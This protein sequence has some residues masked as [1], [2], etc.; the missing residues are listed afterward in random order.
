MNNIGDWGLTAADEH[1]ATDHRVRLLHELRKEPGISQTALTRRL[2]VGSGTVSVMIAELT[3]AGLVVSRGQAKSTGGRPAERLGLNP[4]RPLVLGVDLG[5]TDARFGVLNLHGQFVRLDRAPLPRRRG[6]VELE[7]LLARIDELARDADVTGI[8]VAVPGRIDSGTGRVI[9]A[10]NLG[11]RDLPLRDEV[12]RATG[13]PVVVNRN[14][15]AALVGEEWWGS[16]PA[17]DPFVFVTIGSGVGAAIK[18]RGR[19]LHGASDA[20]GELG[21]IPVEPDGPPC[22]CGN[23]GCL[24]TL[25]SVPAL[26]TAYRDAQ[27]AAGVATRK[28]PTVASLAA[29]VATDPLAA[30]AFER[31]GDR[32]GTGMVTLVNLLN[33]AVIVLGG[34]LMEAEELVLPRVVA[35]LEG[36]GPDAPG[37]GV[38]VIR[39][40][41]GE[42]A[43]LV[44]AATLCFNALLPSLARGAVPTTR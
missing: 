11:W 28:R 4:D 37:R 34:E 25:A 30:A 14:T 10:S 12:E 17:G 40:T 27:R 38:R 26:L 36:R 6:T 33:P 31:I 32:L 15:T 41:F 22:R 7:P 16:A 35:T 19:F 5:E 13:L 29:T 9:R 1:P 8:G 42:R 39:S 18:V 23:R 43:S 21:H 3:A 20:A 44:G 2:R 24:E